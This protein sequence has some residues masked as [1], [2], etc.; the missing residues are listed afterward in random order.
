MTS[1]RSIYIVAGDVEIVGQ[2]D[3]FGEAD[4]ILLKPGAEIIL[5]APVFHSVRLIGGETFS[6]ARHVYRNFA[7]SSTERIE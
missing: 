2:P 4:L 6:E 7:A 5:R 1:G 3:A